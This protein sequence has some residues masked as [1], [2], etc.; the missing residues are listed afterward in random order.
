MGGSSPAINPRI[1]AASRNGAYN[2]IP[3]FITQTGPIRVA[4]IRR[5]ADGSPAGG[6]VGL[7]TVTGRADASGCNVAQPDFNQLAHE[8]NLSFRIPTPVFGAGL[9]EAIPDSTLLANLAANTVAKGAR[10]IKGRF[11][12]NGNDGTITRFGWKAQ[13]KS[14]MIFAGEA[15][16]VE[17]G[18][19]NEVFPQERDTI[20]GCTFKMAPEDTSHPEAAT[21]LTGFSDTVHFANFMRNLAPPQPA[22]ANDSTTR[23]YQ[24]FN[25][26]GCATCPHSL[27]HHGAVGQAGIQQQARAIVFG[28][29]AASHGPRPRRRH[30]PG[31]RW[32]R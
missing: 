14:L 12:T 19:S 26:I 24:L 31:R 28:L 27:A 9:I 2:Q 10:G 25:Q 20:P 3:A 7:F 6:V 16:N 17:Q 1:A 32:H 11:N 5:N 21:V 30:Q 22:A 29:G 23:G 4:R 15:Y 18:V 8:S 13:N